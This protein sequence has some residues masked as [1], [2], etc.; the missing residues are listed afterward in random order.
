MLYTKST[1]S[2]LDIN[3]QNL[4]TYL[5]PKLKDLWNLTD[6]TYDCFGRAYMNETQD[7][8]IIPEVYYGG[9]PEYREVLFDDTKSAISFFGVNP[10]IK[11]IGAT[12]N[13]QVFLIFMINMGLLKPGV[14]DSYPDELLHTDVQKMC[15]EGIFNFSKTGFVTGTKDVFKEY[16]GARIKEG[17]KYRDM[18]PLHCFRINFNLIYKI[19]ACS[20]QPETNA[21]GFIRT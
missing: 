14:T 8:G 5:Y 10:T 17:I 1:Y 15:Y 3:I 19:T 6:A 11:N 20:A 2:G 21:G 18:S 16:S 9:T 7:A 4:Q 12:A 13:A